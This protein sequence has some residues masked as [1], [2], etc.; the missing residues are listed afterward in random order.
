MMARLLVVLLLSSVMVAVAAAGIAEGGSVNCNVNIPPTTFF[1]ERSP[2]IGAQW[3]W[4]FSP[5]TPT[6][7]TPIGSSPCGSPSYFGQYQLGGAPEICINTT[8]PLIAI[9]SACQWRTKYVDGDFMLTVIFNINC[10]ASTGGAPVVPPSFIDVQ[11]NP[12]GVFYTAN[13]TSTLVC[14]KAQPPLFRVAKMQR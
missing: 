9:G 13:F 10:K 11:N 12:D 7:T 6:T 14:A 4:M 5:T 1:V 8:V 2:V 3:G